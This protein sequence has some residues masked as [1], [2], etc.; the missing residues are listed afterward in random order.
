MNRKERIALIFIAAVFLLGAGFVQLR[1][2]RQARAAAASPIA[3]INPADTIPVESLRIDINRATLHE[4][5][6]LPGIGPKLGQR[7]VDYRNK[8]GGFKRVGQLREVSGI[9]PKRYAAICDLV[10]VGPWSD[11]LPSERPGPD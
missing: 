5:M 8:R 10:V 4:L 11:S 2:L 3:I 7:I 6:A 9:G 1:K